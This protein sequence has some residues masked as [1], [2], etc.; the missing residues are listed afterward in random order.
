MNANL[1]LSILIE[2]LD[3]VQ[4]FIQFFLCFV[5]FVVERDFVV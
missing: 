4:Y 5:Y 3:A 1:T 2:S